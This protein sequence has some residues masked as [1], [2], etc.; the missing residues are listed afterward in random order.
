VL[1]AYTV[2]SNG[3][4]PERARRRNITIRPGEGA[5]IALAAREREPDAVAA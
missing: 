1:G 4:G 5:R 3:A 2:S